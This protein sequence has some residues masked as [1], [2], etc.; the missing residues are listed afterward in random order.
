MNRS[1]T[2]SFLLCTCILASCV[3]E[4]A[5]NSRDAAKIRKDAADGSFKTYV[6]NCQEGELRILYFVE[7]SQFTAEEVTIDLRS[8]MVHDTAD[9]HGWD[10]IGTEHRL[11]RWQLST[12]T[13]L[14]HRLPPTD[15][16]VR[17]HESLIVVFHD[18]H[19][20]HDYQYKR[21]QL[22]PM[23]DSLFLALDEGIRKRQGHFHFR[24][25]S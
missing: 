22:P 12:V 10:E 16:H 15:A 6:E 13:N 20:I 8:G 14:L 19:G 17:L 1:L 7:N 24:S 25:K 5:E 18:N 21:M 2:I 11:N 9:M 3:D 23:I 4:A